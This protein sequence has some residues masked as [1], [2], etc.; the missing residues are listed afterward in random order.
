[1]IAPGRHHV[2][3]GRAAAPAAP[4]P[5]P[6]DEWRELRTDAGA[7]FDREVEIDASE[8]SPQVTWGT[9]P[10]M[11]TDGHR[12]RAR[13]ARRGRASARSS[14][15]RSRPARRSRRSRS[16]GCSSAPAPTPAS[17][18]CA[19]RRRS[20]AAAGWPRRCDAMVVPGSQQVKAQ[21]EAE[22]L[23]EVFRAAGFDWRSAGCSMCL[24]MNPDIAAPG[25]A[26]RLDLQPQL[27]GPPGPR[28]RAPT[29]SARRWPPRRPS[30]ATSSTSGSGS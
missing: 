13:A 3:V 6:L 14:T 25:R 4:D 11:V 23:D 29:S 8:L 17:A 21:A 26:L 16:T 9:N 7:A 28:R 1:M 27:R 22:G 18:T 30:R 10:A 19:R 15:W 2:R 24:G 5:L 20:C 12:R